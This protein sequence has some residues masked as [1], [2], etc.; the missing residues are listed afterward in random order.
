MSTSLSNFLSL[1]ALRNFY[2]SNLIINTLQSS[3]ETSLGIHNAAD[4]PGVEGT[5]LQNLQRVFSM[6]GLMTI[7]QN[8][9]AKG[10]SVAAD[11]AEELTDHLSRAPHVAGFIKL[12]MIGFFP[13]LV[14]FLA[15]GKWRPLA[16]WWMA[17]ASICLWN[18]IWQLLYHVIT[19]LTL[20]AETL[21]SFGA[22][23]DKTSLV[24]ASLIKNR[25]YQA[26]AVY[27]WLQLLVGP[28]FTGLFLMSLRPLLADS[29]PD[30]TPRAVGT[31]ARVAGVGL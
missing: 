28:T 29:T 12:L 24:A 19:S 6:D 1:T 26:Y 2:R 20:S 17:Y 11:R 22:L 23:G 9:S 16:W 5:V 4:L 8:R 10:A 13:I 3:Q 18:P 21:A 7:L 31:V 25:I 30:H 14:F 15:A 27:A